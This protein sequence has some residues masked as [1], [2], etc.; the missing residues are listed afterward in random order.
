MNNNYGLYTN[1]YSPYFGIVIAIL[2]VLPIVLTTLVFKP[3]NKIK[4]K[5]NVSKIE[6]ILNIVQK[7][8]FVGIIIVL[9]ISKNSFDILNPNLLFGVM[10]FFLI[11]YYELYIRYI[12]GARAYKLLYEPFLHIKVPMAIC[13]SFSC[14]FAG[15]WGKNIP[16]IILAIIYSFI[17]IYCEYMIYFKN[18]T[19]YRD[20]YDEKRKLTGKKI[21]KGNIVPKGLYYVTVVVFIYNPKNNK[22]LMQKRTKDKGGKWATTSGHP[23]SGQTSI[24][25]MITEIYEELG[26]SV[27]KEELTL[28]TTVKRKNKFVDIY[29]LESCVDIEKLNIQK[30]E[31]TD[32]EWMTKSEVDKFYNAKKYKET[33]YKY[34]KEILKYLK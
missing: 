32:V 20:L 1:F 9:C 5:N 25:G 31:L 29:Y 13:H 24:E 11:L 27:S 19:E 15:L 16:L 12:F 2:L 28:K 21:L 4:D 30:E 34:F 6:N 26:L 14:I 3:K 7:I 10:L 23:I 33:H 18:F 8:S 22:W 17:H